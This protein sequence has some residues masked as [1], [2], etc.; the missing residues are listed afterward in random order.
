[1]FEMYLSE[2]NFL[3]RSGDRMKVSEFRKHVFRIR[4]T[5]TPLN[6]SWIPKTDLQSAKVDFKLVSSGM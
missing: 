2:A 4:K 3:I 1:M 5:S 6:D